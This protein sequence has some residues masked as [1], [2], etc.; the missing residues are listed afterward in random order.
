MD[1]ANL[2]KI[3]KLEEKQ[4]NLGD[5]FAE[6]LVQNCPKY[7]FFCPEFLMIDLFLPVFEKL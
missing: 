1:A 7:L 5:F 4:W 2:D 6:I 3:V